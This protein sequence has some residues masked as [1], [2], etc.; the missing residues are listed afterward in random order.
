VSIVAA[1]STLGWMIV[2]TAGLS[3]L[4]L[5]AQPPS[6]DLGSLLGRARHLLG[7]APH[8]VLVPGSVI[9]VL[10]LIVNLAA[11]RLRDRLDPKLRTGSGEEREME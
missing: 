4:G 3:F 10:V 8:V 5:G 2:E 1:S 11:D 7:T 6:A 9:F